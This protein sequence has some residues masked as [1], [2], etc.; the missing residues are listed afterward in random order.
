MVVPAVLIHKEQLSKVTTLEETNKLLE[1]IQYYENSLLKY[2][3]NDDFIEARGYY[4]GEILKGNLTDLFE[5]NTI[6]II[7]YINELIMKKERG[8]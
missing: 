5:V 8:R 6:N 4:E 2:C 3:S 1:S 7:N